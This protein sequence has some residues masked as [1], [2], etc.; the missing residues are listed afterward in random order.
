MQ[1]EDERQE[2]DRSAAWLLLTHLRM[3]VATQALPLRH[4]VEAAALDSLYEFFTLARE[5]LGRCPNARSTA[6]VT[7]PALNLDLRPFMSYWHGR[8]SAGQLASLDDRYLFR[9]ELRHIHS[10]LESLCTQLQAI[11]GAR[12]DATAPTVAESSSLS[13]ASATLPFGIPLSTGLKGLGE[14]LINSC[15]SDD[16]ARRR[17]HYGA[18]NAE[19]SVDAVG[20]ALSGG[21]IRSATFALGVVQVLAHRGV[22]KDV[23]FLS[24]VSG[25]GYIGSFIS[26]VLGDPNPGVGLAAGQLPFG[27]EGERES[28]A[29]R[30]LRNH[31]KYLAEGGLGTFVLMAFT[32][33][34]GVWSSL[35]LALPLLALAATALVLALPY[36][37]GGSEIDRVSLHWLVVGAWTAVLAAVIVLQ[38][39]RERQWLRRVEGWATALFGLA[40]FVSLASPLPSIVESVRGHEVQSLIGAALLPFVLGLAGLRVSAERLL[41]RYLFASLVLTGPVFFLTALLVCIVVVQALVARAWWWPLVLTSGCLIYGNW[42]I[43]LNFASLHRYYRDR[44]SRTYLVR[45]GFGGQNVEHLDDQM[46]SDMGIAKGPATAPGISADVYVKAPVHLINAA[47][48]VPGSDN[49]NLRGRDADFFV[50][51]RRYC[52][53][54]LTGWQPTAA[55]ESMDRHLDVG[56]AM[57]ISGAAA[58]PQMGALTSARYTMLMAMM[59]VRLGYWLRKP[60]SGA[61]TVRGWLR[62][63]VPPAGCW[64]FFKE[65][66]GLMTERSNFVNLSDGGHIENLGIYELL[67]RRCRYVIAVDGECDPDHQFHGLLTLV[68]MAAIDLGVTIDPNLQDL[69]P[70]TDGLCGSHFVVADIRYPDAQ[71]PTGILLYVKLSMTGNET[72][73]L[74]QYRREHPAF[75]HESTAQQLFGEQQWEAYRALGEHVG[76][77]LFADYLLDEDSTEGRVKSTS[78]WLEGLR[79]RLRVDP[80]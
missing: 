40:V 55:W 38:L 46:L 15:D 49:P 51:S 66:S 22:M 41:G 71:A 16:I 79:N 30:H 37:F 58:A 6:E 17:R 23:D 2:E 77:S 56:T 80:D 39:L 33:L 59:N 14:G 3:R 8:K 76:Q 74:R 73:Y 1:T 31:S 12:P 34:Y 27:Q 18:K 72:Q 9:R 20:L 36:H 63:W 75:P 43:N 47:L 52:G 35:M 57:A 19:D 11:S 69:R 61:P 13:T 50:F 60:R 28:G 24:T 5:T 44:L 64:Y 29:V 21:G 65:L 10:R 7:I 67:R 32:V 48:N 62:G 45:A 70:A 54:A 4:G 25:G 68:R 26:S 53:S 78:S 42:I